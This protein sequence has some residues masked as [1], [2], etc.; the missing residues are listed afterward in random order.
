VRAVVYAAALTLSGGKEMD[1]RWMEPLAAQ[2]A[3][4]GASEKGT[5]SRYSS[6]SDSYE[7]RLDA[8]TAGVTASYD[9]WRVIRCAIRQREKFDLRPFK[10]S[11]ECTQAFRQT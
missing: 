4:H 11:A 2:D 6:K 10:H 9:H 8:G 5:R 3:A 1:L 7:I